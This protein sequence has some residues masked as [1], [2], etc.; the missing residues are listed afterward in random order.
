MTPCA[1]ETEQSEPI[2]FMTTDFCD[3]RGMQIVFLG[4]SSSMPTLS[5]N[6]SCIALRLGQPWFYIFGNLA[7]DA[8]EKVYSLIDVV[9]GMLYE[10]NWKIVVN[11]G[12]C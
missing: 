9:Y 2:P 4:T 1:G 12:T 6:T 3:H 7:V 5:R 11:S 10:L 8:F